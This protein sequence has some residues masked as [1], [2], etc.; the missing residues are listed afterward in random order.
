MF[1]SP[2]R[3]SEATASVSDT[4][5]ETESAMEISMAS[6][7]TH[8]SSTT[9]ASHRPAAVPTITA[10]DPVLDQ[11][12]QRSMISSFLGGHQGTTP[13]PRQSFCNYLKIEHLEEQDILAFR[14]ATVK[15]RSG[16]QYIAEE[17]K[18]QVTT[19]QQVITF[20]LPEATQATAARE[21]ILTIPD[22]HQVSK[23]VQPAESAQI[24]ILACMKSDQQ[25]PL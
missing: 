10:E 24:R 14:N 6:D 16:I 11:F 12:Q 5:R 17:R 4:S 21:Y 1:K 20:Q 19:T 25:R 18:R 15:L 2:L 7:V 8:R 3:P 9:S 13:N 22:T 23:P